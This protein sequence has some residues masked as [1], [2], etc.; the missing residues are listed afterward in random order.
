MPSVNNAG[1]VRMSE[2]ASAER[3]KYIMP[4]LSRYGTVADLTKAKSGNQSD[5]CQ[6]QTNGCNFGSS[7]G[8]D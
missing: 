3:R 1:E 8:G 4:S 6:L 7:V 2:T 5:G